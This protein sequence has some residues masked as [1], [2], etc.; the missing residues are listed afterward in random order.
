MC[1]LFS[2]RIGDT[3]KA[4]WGQI[5]ALPGRLQ[6]HSGQSGSDLSLAGTRFAQDCALLCITF[7]PAPS[8]QHD[9]GCWGV[10]LS[11]CAR[12]VVVQRCALATASS[13]KATSVVRELSEGS[14]G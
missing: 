5:R 13:N 6:H 8:P 3:P 4:R 10:V 14:G 2:G 12:E 1:Q 7:A 11:R 9:G